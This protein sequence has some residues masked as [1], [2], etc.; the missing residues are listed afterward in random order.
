MTSRTPRALVLGGGPVACAAALVLARRFEVTLRMDRDATR[1]G[2]PRVDSVPLQTLALLVELGAHPD[3]LGVSGSHE[4]MLSAWE[5]TAPQA[6]RSFPKA[7]LERRRFDAALQALAL[8]H[9]KISTTEA[10][11]PEGFDLVAD[12]TGRR[13]VTATRIHRCEPGW[14]AR[15]RVFE[16]RF[17]PAQ[18]AFRIAALPFGYAYRLGTQDFLTLG[19]VAPV[20]SLPT[21]EGGLDDIRRAGAGWILAGL[22][23][24]EAFAGGRGG[25]CSAQWATSAAT[26]LLGD[27]AFAPD[28]LSAQGLSV[29][30]ADAARLCD[31]A[32]QGESLPARI[33]AHRASL[34]TAVSRCTHRESAIW[35]RYSR[36]LHE[37]DNAAAF[38]PQK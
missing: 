21:T 22:P 15:T 32:P 10:A 23:A 27:A 11:E 13:A 8:T 29:G 36:G 6:N 18:A 34:R 20:G 7:H 1:L 17:T 38:P 33:G 24:A 16:G 30:L 25:P 9:R 5:T 31:P 2:A 3:S 35:R 19:L 14:V 4:T 28:I 37:D 26:R 12:A